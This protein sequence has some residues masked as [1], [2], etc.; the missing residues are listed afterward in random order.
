MAIARVKEVVSFEEFETQVKEKCYDSLADAVN[1]V[2]E[3]KK[4]QMKNMKII[5]IFG[6]LF[7]FL[8]FFVPLLVVYLTDFNIIYLSI[9][10]I[11]CIIPCLILISVSEFFKKRTKKELSKELSKINFYQTAFKATSQMSFDGLGDIDNA[12]LLRTQNF[13]SKDIPNYAT[14]TLINQ[15]NFKLF[16]KYSSDFYNINYQWVV[17]Y[18]NNK[19]TYNRWRSYV[20]INIKDEVKK[21]V[22]F[23]LFNNTISI[24]FEK[25]KLENQEFNSKANLQSNDQIGIRT[26]FTPLTQ[27]LIMETRKKQEGM[28]FSKT[29]MFLIGNYIVLAGDSSEGFMVIN[30][31]FSFSA[32]KI[33]N[34]IYKDIIKDVYSFYLALSYAIIPPYLSDDRN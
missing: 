17:E 21:L 2:Y 6:I 20:F 4:T 18:K 26:I 27:E 15:F 34:S 10:L 29:S 5:F 22:P 3:P 13:V 30:F 19:T 28:L 11:L 14:K 1:K 23:A 31:P 8:A 12:S 32:E 24:G 25:V 16:D 7:G 33:I 9:A